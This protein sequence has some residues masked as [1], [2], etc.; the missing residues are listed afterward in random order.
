MPDLATEL[1]RLA[2]ADRH[3]A[4]AAAS[5]VAV[6]Q[7][8]ASNTALPQTEPAALLETMKGTLQAMREHRA[9]IVKAIEAIRGDDV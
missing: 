3:I 7:T 2:V 4:E 1:Q 6:E 9:L 5:I 8:L